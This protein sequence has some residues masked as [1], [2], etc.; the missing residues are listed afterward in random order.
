MEN[1]QH[2]DYEWKKEDYNQGLSSV[3]SMDDLNLSQT[4]AILLRI[5]EI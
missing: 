4:Q 5:Q 1:N 2:K 3:G